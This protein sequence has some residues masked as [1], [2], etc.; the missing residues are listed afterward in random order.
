MKNVFKNEFVIKI[1]ESFFGRGSFVVFTLLFSYVCTKLYGAETFG[2]FTYAFTLISI[3]M[4]FA[5]S[6]LDQGMMYSLPKNGNK[7]VSFSFLIN[8]IVSMIIIVIMWFFVNDNYIKFMLPI[9]WLFSV[10]HLF[11]GIYRSDGK[12]K[13]Y[14]FINGFLTMI[15]RVFAII[16]FYFLFGQSPYGI[17]LGVYVSFIFSNIL[18][19]IRYKNRF[20][21]II[22][23]KNYLY[24]SMT[25]ILA[26]S[27]AVLINK[28]D[29]IMLGIM[30]TDTDVGIYAITVQI[31]Q[32][33]S[34]VL[35]V[36][37]TVF[38]PQIAKMFHEG[39]HDELKALYVKATRI[40]FVF[41]FVISTIILLGSEF[42]LSIFGEEFILGQNALVLR[43]I[44]QFVNIAVGGVWLMLSMT[45]EPKFQMYAHVVAFFI[46]IILNF[47][48]IPKYGIDG[49]AFASM[50]TI[51]FTN[52]VG[53]SIV[54]KKFNVKVFRYI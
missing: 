33:V 46:N 17:A 44:A 2:E 9:I 35:M 43:T 7:H 45:G 16:V 23:D 27:M 29:I 13:Q 15:L 4:T 8:F 49:A 54:S 42:F 32:A 10:E 47:I 50:I 22:F 51:I 52:L 25:L 41:S 31:S 18:Y 5:K 19:I 11:F 3:L 48:L 34:L 37:N 20:I 24:Y 53:Y 6:G 28:I 39:K 38:A 30:T 26:S 40:L 36:F 14:F 21:R 1:I 12:I